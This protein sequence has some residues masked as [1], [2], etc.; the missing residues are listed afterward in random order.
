S[1]VSTFC[2]NQDIRSHLD[3][4]ISYRIQ[5]RN[6]RGQLMADQLVTKERCKQS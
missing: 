2:A 1:P 5:M 4:A 3:V 6:T